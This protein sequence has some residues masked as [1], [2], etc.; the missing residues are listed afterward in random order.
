MTD[1]RSDFVWRFKID[2]KPADGVYPDPLL[3]LLRVQWEQLLKLC[4]PTLGDQEVKLD[5]FKLMRDMGTVH[6]IFKDD[7]RLGGG[8]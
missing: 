2:E 6:P 7:P 1:T 5:G 3:E 4:V 8:S